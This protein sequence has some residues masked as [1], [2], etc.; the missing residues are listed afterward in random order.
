MTRRSGRSLRWFKVGAWSWIATGTG[1]TLGDIA[2][3][4]F[5]VDSTIAVDDM[6]RSTPFVLMGLHRTYYELTMGF[7]LIMGTC[8]VFVGILFLWIARLTGGRGLRPTALLALAMSVVAL[9]LSAWLEPPPPIVL[10][11]LAC[12]GF[13]V[14][15][16]SGQPRE[17]LTQA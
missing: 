8:I 10:F 2:T 12:V 13:A 4:F 3:R 14:A 7:S 11:S 5:P 16:R 17:A 6:M 9:A 1:H 15:A